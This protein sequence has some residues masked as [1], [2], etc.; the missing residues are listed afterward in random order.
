MEL[1][2]RSTTK[3]MRKTPK[4]PRIGGRINWIP[5]LECAFNACSRG[6]RVSNT[7][8]HH[9][10]HAICPPAHPHAFSLICLCSSPCPLPSSHNRISARF[11]FLTNSGR[12]S[13]SSHSRLLQFCCSISR[14]QTKFSSG[15]AIPDLFLFAA[16]AFLLQPCLLNPCSPHGR[17]IGSL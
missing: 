9:R 8:R 14:I 4:L 6:S 1:G 2:S 7:Q 17:R 13:L 3:R 12:F 15:I 10:P 5:I 16:Y 11:S